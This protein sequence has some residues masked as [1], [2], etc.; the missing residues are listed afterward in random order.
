MNDYSLTTQFSVR[1]PDYIFDA[2]KK[3]ADEE[4]RTVSNM[5]RVILETHLIAPVEDGA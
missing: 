4:R 2:L 1:L 3:C 5:I